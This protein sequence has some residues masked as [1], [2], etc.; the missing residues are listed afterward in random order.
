MIIFIYE[1]FLPTVKIFVLIFIFNL[2]L[3]TEMIFVWG[4]D[5]RKNTDPQESY[6]VEINFI[7]ARPTKSTFSTKSRGGGTAGRGRGRG[8][9][10]G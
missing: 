9:G 3:E 5:C 8:R 7:F 2:E 10:R 6:R 4:L 1:T